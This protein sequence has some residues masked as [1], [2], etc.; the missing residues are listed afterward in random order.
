MAFAY[1]GTIYL[2]IMIVLTI[3]LLI[4]GL[5]LVFTIP[6]SILTDEISTQLQQLEATTAATL[7]NR[8]DFL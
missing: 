6:L 4:I 2:R 3:M 5:T 7:P 8:L 1:A